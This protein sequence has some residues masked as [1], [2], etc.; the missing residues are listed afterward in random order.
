MRP[1]NI[2]HLF[3]SVRDIPNLYPLPCRNLPQRLHRPVH[4]PLQQRMPR[5]RGDCPLA[6][7]HRLLGEVRPVVDG[8]VGLE[9]DDKTHGAAA[10]R[11]QPVLGRDEGLRVKVRVEAA[12]REEEEVAEEVGLD[13]GVAEGVEGGGNFGAGG[14]GGV[15]EVG[16][17]RGFD[18]R[19]GVA[20]GGRDP[21]R[22]EDEVAVEG[23]GFGGGEEDLPD[24]PGD[25]DRGGGWARPAGGDGCREDV[26][27]K[28]ELGGDEGEEGAEEDPADPAADGG[29]YKAHYL[30]APVAV[31]RFGDGERP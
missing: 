20:G 16:G 1:R 12:A 24:V 21:V 18:E 17:G 30:F 10:V 28:E 3:I 19:V 26:W 25:G 14:E 13:G 11:R 8:E 5:C 2:E 22:G 31:G 27:E 7:L 9:P 4:H 23:L 29:V 15:D 6:E